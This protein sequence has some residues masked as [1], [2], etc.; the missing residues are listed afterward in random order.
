MFRPV[1]YVAQSPRLIQ[2]NLTQFKCDGYM[3]RL[4]EVSG[5]ASVFILDDTVTSR[6]K[7][8]EA[9]Q[10]FIQNSYIT[11]TA[12]SI[13]NVQMH[14]NT[15]AYNLCRWRK[16][17]IE[18][19]CLVRAELSRRKISVLFFLFNII[20]LYGHI[21]NTLFFRPAKKDLTWWC[22]L[23]DAGTLQHFARKTFCFSR[24]ESM[25]GVT[26]TLYSQKICL[27]QNYAGSII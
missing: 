3:R 18:S 14:L 12:V 25:Y 19:V 23:R 2:T 21:I 9:N 27:G 10:L 26:H 15:G 20:E 7:I 6:E 22:G 5:N 13:Y 8:A 4:H 11:R 16:P 17:T 1:L 24:S